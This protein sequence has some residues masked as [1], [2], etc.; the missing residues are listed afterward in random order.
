MASRKLFQACR[1]S[2][3]H[4]ITRERTAIGNA[5]WSYMPSFIYPS[6]FIEPFSRGVY[7]P[8][9]RDTKRCHTCLLGIFIHTVVNIMVPTI[10][11]TINIPSVTINIPSVIMS[12]NTPH[13][14]YNP[15]S[16]PWKKGAEKGTVLVT[17]TQFWIMILISTNATGTR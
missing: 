3:E 13:N 9:V 17:D 11:I 5:W 10:T 8:G 7:V 4:D 6:G 12:A 16:F 14:K 2:F 1:M 15:L